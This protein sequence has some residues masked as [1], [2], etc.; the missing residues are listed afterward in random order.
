MHYD[1]VLHNKAILVACPLRLI[2][3]Y[4]H[5]SCG[6]FEDLS[7]RLPRPIDLSELY[8]GE[9]NNHVQ[10]KLTNLVIEKVPVGEVRLVT[11]Y[12][13][14]YFATQIVTDDQTPDST[15]IPYGTTTIKQPNQVWIDNRLI[16]K[17]IKDSQLQG[18]YRE[19]IMD[20]SGTTML[21]YKYNLCYTKACLTND[22]VYTLSLVDHTEQPGVELDEHER[23][24]MLFN[25]LNDRLSE[26][27]PCVTKITIEANHTSRVHPRELTM[28]NIHALFQRTFVPPMYRT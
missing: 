9:S 17:L 19:A 28:N 4:N 22:Y 15:I 18:A 7:G 20:G 13:D 16:V 5:P 23:N 2:T 27:K 12:I 21:G 24:E 10:E 14:F 25:M 3:S 11:G 6:M 26:D 8:I 1:L